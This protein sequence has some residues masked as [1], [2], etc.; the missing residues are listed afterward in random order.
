MTT[1]YKYIHE[2]RTLSFKLEPRGVSEADR[3]NGYQWLGRGYLHAK[4][5]R[6]APAGSRKWEEWVGE[7][8]FPTYI[9]K[10]N[11]VWNVYITPYHPLRKPQ[12]DELPGN[13][14]IPHSEPNNV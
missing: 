11:G 10:K 5:W 6:E 3:L 9:E 8:Y 7:H 4:A 12:C 1:L 13:V 2:L 14:R